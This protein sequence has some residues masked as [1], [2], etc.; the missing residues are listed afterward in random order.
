[1]AKVPCTSVVMTYKMLENLIKYL[2]GDTSYDVLM[3][4][5]Q[6]T[7]TLKDDLEALKEKY[8]ISD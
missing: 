2:E 5:E 1:M 7:I 4:V 8:D 3:S 6:T